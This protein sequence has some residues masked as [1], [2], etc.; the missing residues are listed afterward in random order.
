MAGIGFELKKLFRK[1]GFFNIFRGVLYASA[2]TI[3]PIILVI[4][5]LLA[6]NAIMKYFYVPYFERDILS[7][8]IL[9]AFVFSLIIATSI[10]TV[11][12]RYISDKIFNEEEEDIIPSLYGSLALAI[13]ISGALGG[14][15]YIFAKLPPLFSF[16]AYSLMMIL[17]M[18]FVLMYYVSAIKEY[19]KI[20]MAFLLGG[21]LGAIVGVILFYAFKI[22]LIYAIL[23]AMVIWFFFTAVDLLHVIRGFFK[24]HSKKY[25]EFLSYFKQYK[26]I[27]ISGVLYIV[28]LYVHNFIF[29]FSP[30]SNV[31]ADTY[32]SCYT[33]DMASFLAMFTNLS[34][35]VI[36]VVKIETNFYEKYQKY[37]YAIMGGSLSEIEIAKRDMSRIINHELFFITEVQLIITLTLICAGIALL[38]IMGFGGTI[39]DIY[40]I[41]ALGYYAVFMMYFLIVFLYYFDDQIGAVYI[42]GVFFSVT[43]AMTLLSLRLGTAFYG[44]GLLLG[45]ITAW[46]VGFFRLKIL[47]R[48]ID[49]HMFCK[50]KA[51]KESEENYA[52]I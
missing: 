46:I 3:G 36:F 32:R 47:L 31:V 22:E 26:L 13:C 52:K 50:I 9:Y 12:S 14:S 40:P 16:G 11:L 30:I 5:M 49:Y 6:I 25:F 45:G 41:L 15:L 42:S 10:G 48:D 51:W 33:Y 18:V 4:T 39:L 21:L 37:C 43:V 8:A 27:F 38:P 23:Y 2:A 24:I 19:R 35:T 7:G 17:S 28:G 29:W 34:A 44:L 20:T 1:F